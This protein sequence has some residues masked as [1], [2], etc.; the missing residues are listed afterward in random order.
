M[1]PQHVYK[2]EFQHSLMNLGVETR[3]CGGRPTVAAVFQH[4]LMNLGVETKL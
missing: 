1:S 3:E 2:K 4:S